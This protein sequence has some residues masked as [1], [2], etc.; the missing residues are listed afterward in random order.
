MKVFIKIK[1]WWD[2][3]LQHRLMGAFVL[4]L[5][6]SLT[7][8]GI[9][10]IITGREGM[11]AQATQG[12]RQ[13]AV[14]LAKQ[15]NAEYDTILQ[16]VEALQ[17]ELEAPGVTLSLQARTLINHRRSSPLT[18]QALYLFDDQRQLLIHLQEPLESVLKIEDSSHLVEQ[19]SIP[20]P[21]EIIAV[22]DATLSEN[23]FISPI[24]I[25]DIEYLPVIYIG[26]PVVVEGG[27]SRQILI[28]EIGFQDIWKRIDEIFSGKPAGHSSCRLTD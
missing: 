4:T 9:L 25:T 16:M 10:S 7:I 27:I 13:L 6:T 20:L 23:R 15:I 12:N 26:L 3:R 24:R 14:H 21:E 28:A 22:Y 11:Q 19:P 17:N 2:A 18:Y 5:F 8:L 1:R